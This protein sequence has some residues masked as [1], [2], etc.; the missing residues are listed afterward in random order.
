MESINVIVAYIG[1]LI[2]WCVKFQHLQSLKK[3]KV[4]YYQIFTAT[5]FFNS[6]ILTH[7]SK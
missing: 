7:F 5:E 2:L 3:W 6:Q 1:I 4:N